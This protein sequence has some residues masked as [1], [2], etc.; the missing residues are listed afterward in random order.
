[1]E[2]TKKEQENLINKWIFE[3][4]DK[5]SNDDESVKNFKELVLEAIND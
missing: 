5:N 2:L 1:M 3:C 4:V